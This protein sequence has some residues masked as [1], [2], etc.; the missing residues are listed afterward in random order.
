MWLW[1]MGTVCSYGFILRISPRHTQVKSEELIIKISCFR[2][3]EANASAFIFKR[4]EGSH[5]EVY[6]Q[7][8]CKLLFIYEVCSSQKNVFIPKKP[9]ERG[10]ILLVIYWSTNQIRSVDL[11]TISVCVANSLLVLICRRKKEYNSLGS[12]W[13]LQKAFW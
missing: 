4:T 2:E 3:Q 7:I 5:D 11:V 6:F 9:W 13:R 1:H 12:F 10:W 8:I